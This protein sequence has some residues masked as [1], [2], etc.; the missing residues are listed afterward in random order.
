MIGACV[1]TNVVSVERTCN[2]TR[3]IGAFTTDSAGFMVNSKYVWVFI[4]CLQFLS[5]CI[6]SKFALSSLMLHSICVI[7]WHELAVAFSAMLSFI[8]IC[9]IHATLQKA[10]TKLNAYILPFVQVANNMKVFHFSFTQFDPYLRIVYGYID[11]LYCSMSQ[12]NIV[13]TQKGTN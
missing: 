3:S 6:T 2:G 7:G 5:V 8:I 11:V 9:V 10:F 1:G 13:I 12:Q 4:Y